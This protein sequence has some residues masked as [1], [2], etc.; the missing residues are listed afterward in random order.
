MVH[1]MRVDAEAIAVW[2]D[3][4][5]AVRGVPAAAA[6]R[7]TIYGEVFAGIALLHRGAAGAALEELDAAP[8]SAVLHTVFG[9]WRSSLLV[10]AVVL[11]G[12][13]RA[14]DLIAAAEAD[15]AA[16]PVAAA[17]TRRVWALHNDDR[18]A[19]RQAAEAMDAAGCR[20]QWGRTLVLM[21]GVAAETG[22]DALAAMWAAPMAGDRPPF[23]AVP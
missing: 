20:Y 6:M 3:V 18:T 22:R 17:L 11:A 1:R 23:Q 7:G 8:R 16:S 14:S 12:E 15:V 5:A 4:V 2:L 19:M 13:S 9:S 21:G 10:E